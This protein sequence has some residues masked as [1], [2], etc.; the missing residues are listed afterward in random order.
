MPSENSL[1]VMPTVS[2]TMLCGHSWLFEAQGT[3]RQTSDYTFKKVT[4]YI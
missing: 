4:F 1:A 2:E 3:S